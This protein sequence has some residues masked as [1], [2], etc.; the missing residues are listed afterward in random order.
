MNFTLDDT[1][2]AI[3]GLARRI[4]IEQERHKELAGATF[5]AEPWNALGSTGLLEVDACVDQCVVLIEQGRTV[6][7]V[8]LWAR[9]ATRR[10]ATLAIDG[11]A[12]D[13]QAREVL[14]VRDGAVFSAPLVV[15]D[16]RRTTA[17]AEFVVDVSHGTKVDLDAAALLDRAIV[18]RCALGV[19]LAERALEI[20]ATY[21]SE[22]KQFERP[23]GSFQAVQ[24][25]AANAYIDLEA[26]RLTMLQAAW[27]IDEGLDARREAAIAQFWA[28]E[29]GQRIVGTAQHLHGGMGSDIDYPL[30][31]YTLA[32]K[33][34]ELA[35]G[36]ATQTLA[37]MGALL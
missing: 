20:T 9:Y 13:D 3:R 24:Q 19:G 5:D 25:R 11:L 37:R 15:L 2:T 31:R 30:H 29:A 7:P 16:K 21:V 12:P 34:I 22:R 33:E 6:A 10:D 36:G 4:F 26:M 28:S 17:G 35:F 23:L 14:F 32:M 18:L 27:R 8:P 1:Q